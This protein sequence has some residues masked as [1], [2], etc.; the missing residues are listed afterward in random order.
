MDTK[1]PQIQ[2][3][4]YKL[5]SGF[6]L[7]QSQSAPLTPAFVKGQIHVAMSSD[8]KRIN[9]S[10]KIHDYFGSLGIVIWLPSL[11]FCLFVLWNGWN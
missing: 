5:D 11:S 7:L 2:R 4:N 8:Y 10:V 3:A 9:I 1:E 6:Q